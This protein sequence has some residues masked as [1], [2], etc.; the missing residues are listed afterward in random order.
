MPETKTTNR[1]TNE[2]KTTNKPNSKKNNLISFDYAIKYLLRDKGDYSVVEQFVSALLKSIGYKEIKILALLESE[3]NKEDRNNKRSIADLV[4]EDE[5]KHK[6][7]I[8]IERSVSNSFIHKACFNTSRLIVD[9]VSQGS[10]YTQIVKVFHISLLYFQVGKGV[11]YHGKTIIHEIDT[12][13]RLEVHIENP[14]TKETF[15]A[16]NILPEYFI[17]SIPGFNDHIEKEMDDWLYVMKHSSV[18]NKFY[19]SYMKKV[20]SKLNVL[21]MTPTER[22]NYIYHQ[23]KL[24][25]DRDQLV[26]AEARGKAEGEVIGRAEG[27]VIGEAKGK[28][29]GKIERNI[30]IA[31]NL[32]KANIPINIIS[33]STG[34]S[35][36]QIEDLEDLK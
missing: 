18:P 34:L 32:L 13:E 29:E 22:D 30:E 31:K 12:K 16:T 3:S 1:T 17:I 7:I 25:S 11:L 35:K 26:T 8:E 33:E 2:T 19:S 24:Y 15:D 21:K 10:D 14:E 5:D 23:K 28:I 4:V 36:E 6:Y 9:N 27:E 20:A